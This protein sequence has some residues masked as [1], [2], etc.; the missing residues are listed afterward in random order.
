MFHWISQHK[1]V[2]TVFTNLGTLC[3][4]LVYAQLLYWGF[5][6][7]RRPRLIINRGKKKD[8]NALCIISN[9][10][11]ESIFI[12]YII[13]ELET[14]QGTITMDVTDFEQQYS[15]GEEIDSRE[16]GRRKLSDSSVKENTRQGPLGSGDF[17]HIGTFDD[18]IRRMARDEGIEMQDHRP[19]GDLAF[20]SLTIRLIGIYGPEDMPVG[21]ER[22][23]LLQDNDRYCSLTPAT[24]DTRRLAS[25]RERR[26]LRKRVQQLNSTN[27]SVASSFGRTEE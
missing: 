10:S 22:Q 2:L 4:W 25:K 5:R 14:S 16:E 23:F 12:E 3:I 20:K 15:E 26:E 7:Q 18:L 27:F 13:A 24:W 6:R 19:E 11:A 1:D 21:A 9:M 17:L 8:I